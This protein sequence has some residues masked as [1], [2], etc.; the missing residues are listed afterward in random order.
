[1]NP[2]L[3]TPSISIDNESFL[4]LIDS[5]LEEHDLRSDILRIC[6][7]NEIAFRLS[8]KWL[9]AREGHCPV[10][11][12]VHQCVSTSLGTAENRIHAFH[13]CRT[14]TDSSYHIDG[15]KPLAD[16]WIMNEIHHW[17]GT[18]PQPN[19]K[20]D[21]LLQDYLS[22]NYRGKVCAVKSLVYNL[23]DGVYGHALGSEILRKILSHHCP[24]ATVSKF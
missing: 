5:V 19:S 2:N 6:K 20:A 4:T 1:M 11:E 13:G 14:F 16:D 24:P 15:I 23:R 12:A 3:S 9:S 10:T 17:A 22:S 7:G 18:L 21:K 8:C